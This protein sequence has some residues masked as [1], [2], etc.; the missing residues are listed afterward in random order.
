MRFFHL[1]HVPSRIAL[2]I[3]IQMTDEGRER[4]PCIGVFY[5]L[6]PEVIFITCYQNSLAST[7]SRGHTYPQGRQQNVI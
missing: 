5:G 6:G 3:N 7:Q 4:K 2:N 1:Q